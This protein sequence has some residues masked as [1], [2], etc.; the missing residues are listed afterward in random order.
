[1]FDVAAHGALDDGCNTPTPLLAV[2]A[3]DDDC[4]ECGG[5]LLDARSMRA[6]K[7]GCSGGSVLSLAVETVLAIDV[8]DVAG[9]AVQSVGDV[10]ELGLALALTPSEQMKVAH[11][12][13]RPF[14]VGLLITTVG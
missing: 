11:P 5:S 2:V 3:A 7:H 1:M 9:I 14:T 10:L 13:T 6:S 4:V 8:D 12:A